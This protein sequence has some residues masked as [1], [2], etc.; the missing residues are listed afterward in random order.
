MVR[1]TRIGATISTV[2]DGKIERAALLSILTLASLFVRNSD[3][4]FVQTSCG[5]ERFAKSIFE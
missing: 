4:T 2:R 3:V 5:E 1:D